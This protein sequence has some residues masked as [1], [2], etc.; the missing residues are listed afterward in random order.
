MKKHIVHILR[1][2]LPLLFTLYL[3]GI[4]FFTHPHVVNGVIIVHSHVFNG[5]HEHTSVEFE[6]IFFVSNFL[7]DTSLFFAPLLTPLFLILLGIVVLGYRA[8]AP[9]VAMPGV[10]QLRAPP[11]FS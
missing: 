9:H 5:E 3:G 8:F 2:F 4:T 7:A 11:V 10:I 1:Y 6:T